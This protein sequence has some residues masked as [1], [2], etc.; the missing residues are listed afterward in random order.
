LDRQ[1]GGKDEKPRSRRLNWLSVYTACVSGLG[2]VTLFWSLSHYSSLPHEILLF[3][4][5][6]TLAELTTSASLQP[7]LIFSIGSAVVFASLLLFGM[8]PAVLIGIVGGLAITVVR[9]VADR[10]QKRSSGAPFLQRALFNMAA[11]ALAIVVASIVYV[12]SG[13]RVGEVALLSNLL[14]MILA[15]LTSEFVNSI[16]VIEAVSLQTGKSPLSIWKQTVSW[17]T[18]INILSMILGGGGLALGYQI[19]GLLGASVFILPL[20]LIIYAFQ[21]YVS[22]TKVQMAQLQETIAELTHAQE[23]IRRQAAHLKALN[24][25]IAAAAAAPDLPQLLQTALHH[26]LQALQLEKGAIWVAEDLIF[27]GIP[28]EMGVAIRN[29]VQAVGTDFSRGIALED[30]GQAPP[31]DDIRE[32]AEQIVDFGV[33][34]SL[35][36][37][38]LTDD[39][40]VGGLCVAVTAPRTWPSEE[41]AL[42]EAVGRQLGSAADRVHLLQQVRR[43]AKELEVAVAQLQEL[44]R[45]KNEFMQNASH[46]LRTPLALIRGYMEL[47]AGGEFGELP[48]SQIGAI[49]VIARQAEML[50][51]LVED[52]T[53]S[54]AAKARSFVKEPVALDELLIDAAHDLRLAAE[55]AGLALTVDVGLHLPMIF[56]EPY[57]IRRALDNLVS[58]AIKFTPAGGTITLRLNHNRDRVILQV[59]DTGI[60][61]PLA[62]QKRIFERFVQVDGSSAR[63]YG[64]MGLGLA[65]VKEIVEAHGGKVGVESKVGAGSTF[66]V[67]LPAIDEDAVAAASRRRPALSR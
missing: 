43:H 52:I 7:E 59:A 12:W 23:E 39:R 33:R 20:A 49:E 45:L 40:R 41:I 6:I 27:E 47:M 30:W 13:G 14:P 16:L 53:L 35:I 1:H 55:K 18:A 25:V 65:L 34:A 36:V 66:T 44:D 58:N 11:S 8:W 50:G 28:L 26:S 31:G 2:L 64:G 37:P 4:A 38:V 22:R 61:I 67:N 24:A 10:R 48:A 21:L 19:A 42:V 62:E 63:R 46:E 17:A 56:G 9:D 51:D 32:I 5:L 60:G 54:L 57:Y 15:A 3:I 29:A